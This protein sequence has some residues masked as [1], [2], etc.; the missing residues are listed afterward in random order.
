M[1]NLPVFLSLLV[2]L[3][4]GATACN[5]KKE[6]KN[7][8]DNEVVI[9]ER[10]ELKRDVDDVQRR[11]DVRIVE[12]RAD[13]DT[14]STDAN[15]AIQRQI[16]KLEEARRNLDARAKDIES[17]VERDWEEFKAD[18]RRLINDLD[19]EINVRI[20]LDDDPNDPND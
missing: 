7:D 6:D 3:F 20:D 12:L 2:L 10:T 5:E 4:I 9:R 8:A 16:D 17:D 13:M 19:R 14:V 11:V 18:V 15:A 1:K